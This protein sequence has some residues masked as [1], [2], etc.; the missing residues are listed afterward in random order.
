MSIINYA[1]A[2]NKKSGVITLTWPNLIKPLS[3]DMGDEGQ[4]F[5]CTGWDT[6]ISQI[7]GVKAGSDPTPTGHSWASTEEETPINFNVPII[8][9]TG[10]AGVYNNNTLFVIS[11][12]MTFIKPVVGKPSSGLNISL[13]LT[14][15]LYLKRK[16]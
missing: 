10:G 9:V 7:S 2:L 4:E 5:D 11:N 13:D 8:N 3:V 1:I 6:Y 14:F 12:V 15:K 16:Y